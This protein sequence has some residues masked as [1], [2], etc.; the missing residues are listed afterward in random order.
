LDIEKLH[1]LRIEQN[2]NPKI[3]KRLHPLEEISQCQQNKRFAL[4]AKESEEKLNTLLQKYHMT[5]TKESSAVNLKNIQLSYKNEIINLKYNQLNNEA[6]ILK[7]DAV[8]SVCDENLISRDN[9]RKLSYIEPQLIR[10]H[11]VSQR[12]NEITKLMNNKIQIKNFNLQNE[13]NQLTILDNGEPQDNTGQ[14]VINEKE[15]GNGVFCSIR[16]YLQI[17]IPI[18]KCSVLQPGDTIKLKLGGDGRNVGRKQNHVMLTIC[19]LN[20][21]DE[22]LKP[23]HQY[24]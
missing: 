13:L 6:E 5:T 17:L 20:E 18:W 15:I 24:W 21:K 23:D 11:T 16:D 12:R 19:L 22:V 10:E 2:Q 3:N 4:F 1:Q 8:T 14:I 9:Y 7:L